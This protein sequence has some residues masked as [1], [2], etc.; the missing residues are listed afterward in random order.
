MQLPDIPLIE[1]NQNE[2]ETMREL[3]GETIEIRRD[4]NIRGK[5]NNKRE[6]RE[7]GRKREGEISKQY[8]RKY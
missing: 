5:E 2:S 1:Q 8:N 4:R 3:E 6:K 7:N